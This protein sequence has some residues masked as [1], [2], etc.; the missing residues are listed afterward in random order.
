SL[1]SRLGDGR[2]KRGVGW[3]IY[4]DRGQFYVNLV[5]EAG[6]GGAKPA[7]LPKRGLSISTVG[8]YPRDQWLHVFFTYDGSR[9]TSGIKLYIDGKPA[10]TE[11]RVNSLLE[12]D[13]I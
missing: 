7:A 4:Q 11:P 2:T 9:T 6:E 12:K 13:S 1:L 5:A 10:E 3:E 8:E